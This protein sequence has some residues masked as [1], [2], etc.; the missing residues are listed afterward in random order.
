MMYLFDPLY[1]IILAPG[2]LLA[3]YATMITKST[4]AKYSE[5]ASST[6]ITGSQAAQRL[7]SNAGVHD[8]SIEPVQGFLSDHYDPRNKT[9]RLSPDV[10]NSRSLS[11]IGVAC[12]EAGH[13]LQHADAYFWLGLRSN[14]VPVVQFSSNFSYILLMLGFIL[15]FPG[16][17]SVGIILFSAAVVFSIV[18]LPVE[19]DA[20][21]RA[22]K[23]M[24]STGV[25]PEKE[26][27]A[28][29]KVLNAAFLT[30]V[31][32]A[33]TSLLTLLY[34]ILRAQQRR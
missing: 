32:S 29:G 3:A 30:Y 19:W 28:S 12:H 8:V 20:S 5:V 6:G 14:M 1:F 7:L 13:A 33:L 15:N 24:V 31:A 18:T 17:L 21:A 34:Y 2:L 16:L 10:Y 22:K 25:V 9:L 11:A 23:L 27:V 4:F 26:A